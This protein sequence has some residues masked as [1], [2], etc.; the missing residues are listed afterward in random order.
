MSTLNDLLSGIKEASKEYSIK[1]LGGDTNESSCEWIAI[2]TIGFTTA[3]VPPSRSGLREGDVI[4]VT[5]IYGAMG[6]VAKHG[7]EHASRITWVI[8]ETKR[9]RLIPE[10]GYVIENFY[11][12]ITASTDVSDGLGYTLSM[13]SK[14]SGY[15]IQLEKP[16]QVHKEL[17]EYCNYDSEC[18]LE[19]AL[20]GGEEY[21]VVL[22]VKEEWI[23][24][25]VSELEYYR[26]PY[27]IV[28]RA[29]SSPP[30]VYFRGKKLEVYR[31]DQFR[32]WVQIS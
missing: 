28:G 17:A 14:L 23:S 4:V 29:V 31:Y 25:V 20:T 8:R 10:I 21:G 3:R 12:V 18:I 7:I 13:L 9:P 26:I 1:V 27:S 2:A 6:F 5:G 24:R 15:G 32:K 22:G 11:K 30:G 19:Y 16:P